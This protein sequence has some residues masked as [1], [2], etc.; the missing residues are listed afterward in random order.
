MNSDDIDSDEDLGCI[1]TV[2]SF[3]GNLDI[4]LDRSNS[5]NSS[6]KA[7]S[8]NNSKYSLRSRSPNSPTSNDSFEGNAKNGKKSKAKKNKSKNSSSKGRKSR[9]SKKDEPDSSSHSKEVMNVISTTEFEGS[10]DSLQDIENSISQQTNGNFQTEE[11]EVSSDDDGDDDDNGDVDESSEDSDNNEGLVY[12]DENFGLDSLVD[13]PHRSTGTGTLKLLNL[14]NSSTISLTSLNDDM[15]SLKSPTFDVKDESN[16]YIKVDEGNMNS[17]LGIKFS[18]ACLMGDR[19][20][21]EDRNVI[22]SDILAECIDLNECSK[23]FSAPMAF[24]AVYVS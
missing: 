17:S 1:T 18:K 21:M 19:P 12:F 16:K 5:R 4:Q 6:S 9:K 2:D 15:N 7:S 24:L 13:L 8:K 3:S 10:I 22:K 14:Q 11:S 23:H 20:Y